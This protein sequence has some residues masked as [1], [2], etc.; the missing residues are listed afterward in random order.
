MIGLVTCYLKQNQ[1]PID[2]SETCTSSGGGDRVGETI[3][4]IGMRGGEGE[5]PQRGERARGEEMV[6]AGV[7]VEAAMVAALAVFR[8]TVPLRL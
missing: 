1:F 6:S 7:V 4:S 5:A 8:G 3:T 2:L